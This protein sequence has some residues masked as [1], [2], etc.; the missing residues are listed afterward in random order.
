MPHHATVLLPDGRVACADYRDPIYTAMSRIHA[1]FTQG[2]PGRPADYQ[3]IARWLDDPANADRSQQCRDG[4]K[5]GG[6]CG[7]D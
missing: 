1:R 2:K 6:D 3:Q 5:P 4:L 7:H